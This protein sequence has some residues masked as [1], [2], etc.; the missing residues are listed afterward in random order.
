[1]YLG[2]AG[3][4][5]MLVGV[6]SVVLAIG[7]LREENSFKLFPYLA[8]IMSFLV[9]GVWLVLYVVGAML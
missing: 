2:S 6:I 9:T 1:M 5:S 3:V 8:T 4:A 7:S